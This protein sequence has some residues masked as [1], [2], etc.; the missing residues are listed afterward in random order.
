LSE[1]DQLFYKYYGMSQTSASTRTLGRSFDDLSSLH[2]A[3]REELIQFKSYYKQA[4]STD[5]FLLN[6]ILTYLSRMKGKEIRPTLVFLAA[7]TSGSVSERTYVAATMIELLH[8]ATLI[9]DDVVDEADR[10][11]GLFSINKIW[12][13]KAGVL[14]GDFLLSKGLLIALDKNE[15]EMLKI[16]SNAVRR[17]S[18]GELRQMKASS[19]QNITR[20]K[21]FRI[22]SEKTAS[23]FAACCETGAVSA[24]AHPD[25]ASTMREIGELMGIAFQIQDDLLDY[26]SSDIGK[27][28]GNDIQERKVT[29]PL[30]EAL[31]STDSK[32]NQRI[33]RLFSNKRKTDRD[34]RE[35]IQFVHESGGYQRAKDTMNNFAEKAIVLVNEFPD[36]NAR[37]SLIG[38][39]QYI[40]NRSK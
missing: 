40:T 39:I 3:I 38:T 22:I 23:L 26:G 30:I 13:N 11:R 36:S 32:M 19:L 35:I 34:T 6:Q 7:K 16:V 5:V 8:T 2:H 27:P 12:K 10:R 24:G 37:E 17:M 28:T 33:K 18:E 1:H 21:Y 9:H 29:L 25:K 31:E 4:L 15:F 14:L 20:E